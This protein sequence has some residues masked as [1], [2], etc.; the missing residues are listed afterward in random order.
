MNVFLLQLFLVFKGVGVVKGVDFL[1][2][3]LEFEMLFKVKKGL[4]DF[5]IIIKV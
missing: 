2:D 5:E 1:K 3:V 4:N